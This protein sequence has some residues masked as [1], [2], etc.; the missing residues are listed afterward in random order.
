MEEKLAHEE[1]QLTAEAK[2]AGWSNDELSAK[3]A[4]AEAAGEQE[5]QAVEVPHE[6]SGLG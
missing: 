2:E 1:A 3:L 4:E 6:G 5:V